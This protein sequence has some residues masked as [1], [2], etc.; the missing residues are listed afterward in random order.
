[1]STM[2]RCTAC[3]SSIQYDAGHAGVDGIT[4]CPECCPEC[5][6]RDDAGIPVRSA[7]NA[8][9]LSAVSGVAGLVAAAAQMVASDVNRALSQDVDSVIYE[10]AIEQVRITVEHVVALAKSL[11]V[12]V[13]MLEGSA[14]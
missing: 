5:A 3:G 12:V 2:V 10:M 14:F 9:T 13:E 4:Y 6:K 7:A 11:A 8:M 1:M